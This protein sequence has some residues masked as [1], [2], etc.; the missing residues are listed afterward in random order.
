MVD[1][2]VQVEL[3][4]VRGIHYLGRSG[5]ELSELRSMRDAVHHVRMWSISGCV[6]LV[7]L[8]LFCW[9]GKNKIVAD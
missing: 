2:L 3:Y 6:S 5:Q 9:L 1:I 8:S 4:G 7:G